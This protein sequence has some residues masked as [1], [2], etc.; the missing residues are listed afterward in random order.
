MSHTQFLDAPNH[1][2]SSMVYVASRDTRTLPR[3]FDHPGSHYGIDQTQ[4]YCPVGC[5]PVASWPHGITPVYSASLVPCFMANPEVRLG[6][7]VSTWT[8]RS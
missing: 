1:A 7:G 3:R 6:T 2:P 4:R 8:P 5:V